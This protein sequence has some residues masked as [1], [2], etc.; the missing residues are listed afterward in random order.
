[1]SAGLEFGVEVS[2][3]HEKGIQRVV[4]CDGD[5]DC[6]CGLIYKDHLQ[7]AWGKRVK[8]YPGSCGSK[9]TEE[10]FEVTAPIRT[11]GGSAWTDWAA[12]RSSQG[13]S[14]CHANDD[15]P[16]CPEGK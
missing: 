12:C 10:S 9:P 1:M 13:E 2:T 14:S 5:F 8:T 4:K 6:T 7:K 3:T 11:D 15:L 16:A